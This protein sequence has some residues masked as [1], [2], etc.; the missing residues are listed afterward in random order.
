MAF[1]LGMRIVVSGLQY[2]RRARAKSYEFRKGVGG[3]VQ[4]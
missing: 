1:F 2:V 3:L 4:L